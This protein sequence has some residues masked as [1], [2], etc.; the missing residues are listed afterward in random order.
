MNTYIDINEF[1][2]EY[3]RN[4]RDDDWLGFEPVI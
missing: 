3:E 2:D 4:H 1:L